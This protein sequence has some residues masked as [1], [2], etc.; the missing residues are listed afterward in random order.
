[1][2]KFIKLF[3]FL[4][5]SKL[6]NIDKIVK[7][8][9]KKKEFGAIINIY[10]TLNKYRKACL[11]TIK[12]IDITKFEKKFNAKVYK[13]ES[14]TKNI[15]T[16]LIT[17]IKSNKI[18]ILANDY[19]KYIYNRKSTYSK[20]FIV[21]N[22]K[23]GKLLEY[24]HPSNSYKK[25]NGTINFN[26]YYNNKYIY[27]DISQQS[28]NFNKLTTKNLQ[29]IYKKMKLMNNLLKN[30]SNKFSININISTK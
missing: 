11:D 28:I 10:L 14:K 26:I 7:K 6:N 19:E 16:Y 13:I 5:K 4:T 12:N 22:N 15:K 3:K 23:I 30:I 17:T 27:N 24:I 21:T 18:K 20:K 8:Y 2:I 29:F 9:G 25:I 1:M